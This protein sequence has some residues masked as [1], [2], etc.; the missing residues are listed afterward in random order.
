MPF[1]F[2][3]F[4][5]TRKPVAPSQSRSYVF[6]FVGVPSTTPT[7]DPIRRTCGTSDRQSVGADGFT[8][9]HCATAATEKIDDEHHECEDQQDMDK[10][11][12]R[13][14]ADE[15]KQPQNQQD[16]ENCPKHSHLQQN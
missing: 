15:A 10:P 16:H 11:A 4:R 13:V 6:P 9:L 2:H 1:G 14:R 12:Q 7:S 8:S 5:R 3:L